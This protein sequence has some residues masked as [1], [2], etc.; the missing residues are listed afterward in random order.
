MN[1]RVNGN[2]AHLLDRWND[3]VQE[4]KICENRNLTSLY[5]DEK[6]GRMICIIDKEGRGP[7]HVQGYSYGSFS[8]G[9][10]LQLRHT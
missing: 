10:T 4:C 6:Y 2:E 5:L 9:M 1:Y 8:N 7:N 3:P